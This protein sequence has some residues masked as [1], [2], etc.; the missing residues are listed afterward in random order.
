MTFWFGIYLYVVRHLTLS[1]LYQCCQLWFFDVKKIYTIFGGFF[2]QK[3]IISPL[4]LISYWATKIGMVGYT[5]QTKYFQTV[6]GP[7]SE[8][9][10]TY[11]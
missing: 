4:L 7:F 8:A 10:T 2:L 5:L 11:T 3:L 9:E 1:S 6:N